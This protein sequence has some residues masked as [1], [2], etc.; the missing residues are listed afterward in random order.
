[1]KKSGFIACALALIMVLASVSAF[2]EGK[3]ADS[4]QMATVE[5]VVNESYVPVYAQALKNGEYEISADSSSS[6]FNITACTL[7]VEDGGMYAVMTMSGTGYEYVYPGT[8]EEAAAAEESEYIPF[9]ENENGEHTFTIPVEA[10]DA[11]TQCA[12]FSKKKE[13]W[14]DR[15]LVFR[16]D[17]L[18]VSAFA[19]G[20]FVTAG[21]L[22]LED[23]EYSV[24]AVLSGGSGKAY[25]ESPALL[26]VKDGEAFVTV[27]MS[28]KNYDYMRIEDETYFPVN[29]E[30]NSTFVIPIVF[31]D[32]GMTVFAD[33][34]AMSVPHEIEY[35]LTFDSDSISVK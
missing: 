26:E 33:T 20:Y 18:P 10:L 4:G 1:M 15:T 13:L 9:V 30:G 14:Y 12:A 32:R 5:E 17:S 28:S 27:V 21:T 23:G 7:H 24:D 31:F 8:G 16:A 19:D 22:A 29:E 25:V 3:V 34:V 2:A 11:G 6:M 35:Q